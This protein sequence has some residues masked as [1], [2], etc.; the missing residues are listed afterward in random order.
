VPAELV[1]QKTQALCT[2]E[3]VNKELPNNNPL[4]G[5]GGPSLAKALEGDESYI[6]PEGRCQLL[7][8]TLCAITMIH[9]LTF[10]FHIH[11]CTLP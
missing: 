9:P 3:L 7:P 8:C 10:V 4:L 1:T 2:M 5:T 6:H 11:T